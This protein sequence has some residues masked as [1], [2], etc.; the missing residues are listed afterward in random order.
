M[1][2]NCARIGMNEFDYRIFFFF[3]SLL[4]DS[5]I[6][7]AIVSIASIVCNLQGDRKRHKRLGAIRGFSYN[8]PD[9]LL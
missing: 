3:K 6:I 7:A 9:R 4:A 8:R 2:L 5:H 1:Y